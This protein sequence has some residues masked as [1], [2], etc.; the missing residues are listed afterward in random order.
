MGDH[1]A[2]STEM[3]AER[4][5][6]YLRAEC[7][8]P[9]PV[10]VGP[11]IGEGWS[12]DTFLVERGDERLV[13]RLAGPDHPLRTSPAREARVMAV[14]AGAGLPVPRLVAAV[15]NDAWLGGPFALLGFVDGEAP[16]VWS[17][18]SMRRLTERAGAEHVLR[19]LV[20]LALAVPAVPLDAATAEPPCVLGLSRAEYSIRGDVERWIALL[21]DTSCA[22]RALTAAGAWLAD[23]A[24]PDGEV[25]LQHH[26]FRLGNILFRPDGEPSAILDWEFSGAGDPLCDIGY[27]A[28]PYTLGKLLRRLPALDLREDPTTW[29]L[30]EHGIRSPRPVDPARQRWFVALGIFKMAVALVLTADESKRG[31]GSRRGA[32]L[33]LPILS[34]TE[35][36]MLSIRALT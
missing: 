9:T 7:G 1:I 32:W 8:D 5:A 24:P 11:R 29:V 30:R 14:A 18:R 21:D 25:A 15:D 26:D 35:D 20:E 23:N 28:Q 13:L 10:R 33:E 3:L 34:L 4:L 17:R 16:N 12:V 6:G 2:I 22:R 27:A 36:L 31:G 19:R